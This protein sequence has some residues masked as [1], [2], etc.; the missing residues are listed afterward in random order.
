MIRCP[1]CH[2]N[3]AGGRF[4]PECGSPLTGDRVFDVDVP[5]EIERQASSDFRVLWFLVPTIILLVILGGSA[6]IAGTAREENVVGVTLALVGL[7]TAATIGYVWWRKIGRGP[8]T[9][10]RILGHVLLGSMMAVIGGAA[11]VL[12]LVLMA[13]GAAFIFLLIVCARGL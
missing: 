8:K 7:V 2:I 12:L 11:V 5:L 9:P 10:G 3:L 6:L 13:A 4:C 1:A